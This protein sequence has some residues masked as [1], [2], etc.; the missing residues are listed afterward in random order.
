MVEDA[1]AERGNNLMQV[2]VDVISFAERSVLKSETVLHFESWVVTVVRLSCRAHVHCVAVHPG[3]DNNDGQGR[4]SGA[5]IYPGPAR[6]DR[7]D[8]RKPHCVSDSNSHRHNPTSHR[9]I[10]SSYSHNNGTCQP[11]QRPYVQICYTV[12]GNLTNNCSW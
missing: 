3:M 1:C 2:F 10:P 12:G 4:R 7:A 5:L 8:S 11:Q 9:L 6:M